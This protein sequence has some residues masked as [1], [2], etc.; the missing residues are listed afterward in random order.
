[1]TDM[2]S[3]PPALYTASAGGFS[4]TA[5]AWVRH[6]TAET[7]WFLSVLGS[8]SAVKAVTAALLNQPPKKVFLI[9]G[10][11]GEALSGGYQACEVAPET[12]GTWRNRLT[13]LPRGQGFHGMV[14]T[15][16]AEYAFQREAFLL[17]ARTAEEAP[18]LHYRFLDRR[19]PL[20]MHHS[21]AD[22]LW[23]RGFDQGE[24]EPLD[25]SGILGYW[26]SPNQEMLREELADAVATGVLTVPKE[27][28]HGGA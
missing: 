20:P 24:I 27:D 10:A 11:E 25:S 18:R 19:S 28:P 15:A 7:I 3:G 23:Q 16:L 26:C 13:R 1:M 8:Q 5:D 17:L 9:K 21:W 22:W 14:Y 12:L 6:S 2:A 4:V